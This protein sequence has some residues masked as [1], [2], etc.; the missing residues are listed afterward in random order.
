MP[1]S[2][3]EP[4]FL[5]TTAYAVGV[6]QIDEEHQRLFGLAESLHQAMLQ[7]QGK[8]VLKDLL[9]SLVAYT[10]YH[11]AHEEE[12][13]QRVG[14][15]EYPQHLEQH[16][17]LRARVL[18][19]QQRQASGDTT[20]TIEIMRLIMGWVSSHIPHSDCPIS[21]YMKKSAPSAMP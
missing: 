18:G 17:Q 16:V 5:W 7:G 15:P 11:F 1:D 10:W 12:L 21:G 20:M 9:D 4:M 8:A 19:L 6:P 13:M 2:V 3:V 14:Y